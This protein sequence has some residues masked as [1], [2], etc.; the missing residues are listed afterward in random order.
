M[1]HRSELA[2]LKGWPDRMA[3][4]LKDNGW[5]DSQQRPEE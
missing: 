4:W 5:L 3:D 1:G 2:T